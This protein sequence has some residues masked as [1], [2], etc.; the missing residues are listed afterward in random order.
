MNLIDGDTFGGTP[1]LDEAG[2]VRAA[3]MSRKV[4]NL[5]CPIVYPDMTGMIDL[6]LDTLVERGRKRVATLI[7]VGVY[8]EVGEYLRKAM[9]ARG[10]ITHDRWHQ[11]VPHDV[12]EAVRNNVLMM[13]APGQDRPDGLF[14]V[15][16]NLAEGASTGLVAAGVNV[17]NDVEVVA[18]CNFPWSAPSV[19]PMVRIG[20]DTRQILETAVNIIDVQRQG[21]PA[22]TV[23]RIGAVLEESGRSLP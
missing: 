17:P 1:I 22:P 3:I 4:G 19:L 9:Q 21:Q 13:M 14:I 15:D 8:Q 16:D 6:A 11:I 10:V 5:N 23:T 2:I 7:T 20:F 18:H 12:P